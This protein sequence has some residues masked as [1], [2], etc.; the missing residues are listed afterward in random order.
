[1][2]QYEA[3][4]TPQS[5]KVVDGVWRRCAKVTLLRFDKPSGKGAKAGTEVVFAWS[6]AGLR[7]AQNEA[8]QD[9]MRRDQAKRRGEISGAIER[10][11]EAARPRVNLLRE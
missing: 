11:E 5:T 6:K 9:L 8:A 7:R 10:I 3:V 4:F 2:A 1:M